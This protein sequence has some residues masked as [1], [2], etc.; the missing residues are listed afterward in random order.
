MNYKTKMLASKERSSHSVGFYAD[1]NNESTANYLNGKTRKRGKL[2]EVERVIYKRKSNKKLS[3]D[4]KYFLLNIA[5]IYIK[6]PFSSSSNIICFQY[7]VDRVPDSLERLW[8][9]DRFVGA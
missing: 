2:F 6:M 5:T 9:L 1:L 8:A 3:S 4:V 7:F